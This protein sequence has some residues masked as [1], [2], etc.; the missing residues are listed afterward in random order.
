[1]LHARSIEEDSVDP[2]KRI[3]V[4]GE[5]PESTDD[6]APAEAEVVLY[7][8]D[9]VLSVSLSGGE[10]DIKLPE[11]DYQVH[12][13]DRQVHGEAKGEH[14][15]LDELG[16]AEVLQAVVRLVNVMHELDRE[17]E[18]EEIP[19]TGQSE[20]ESADGLE[21]SHVDGKLRDEQETEESLDQ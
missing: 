10:L 18:V 16:Q 12:R 2:P 15:L 9:V 8:V 13:P 5:A 11:D 19:Q 20:A 3:E 17:E 21:K 14:H 6:I 1:M 7:S 4:V